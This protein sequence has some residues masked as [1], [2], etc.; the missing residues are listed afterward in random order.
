MKNKETVELLQKID[1]LYTRIMEELQ[2]EYIGVPPADQTC[3]IAVDN[4]FQEFFE[5]IRERKEGTK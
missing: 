3:L 1:L 4:A 2:D 5:E